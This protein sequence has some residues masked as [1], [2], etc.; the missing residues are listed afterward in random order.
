[1]IY[2]P[3]IY[4]PRIYY[5]MIYYSM[6]Y[7]PMIYYPMI[8]YPMIYYLMIYYPMIYY[9]VIYLPWGVGVFRNELSRDKPGSGAVTFKL[10]SFCSILR[11]KSGLVGADPA[12]FVAPG[13]LGTPS[14]NTGVR[15]PFRFPAFL[16]LP[17][18]RGLRAYTGV[19]LKC[20]NGIFI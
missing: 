5:P 12:E 9:P 20:S 14:L 6:I 16:S 1:M 18:C 7:Y 2:Y 8:Y 10:K 4:Y 13:S 11:R 17:S 19:W 3:R 15:W